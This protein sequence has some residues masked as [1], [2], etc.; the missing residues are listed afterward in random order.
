M[1]MCMDVHLMAEYSTRH[2]ILVRFQHDYYCGSS[3]QR[4]HVDTSCL[5]L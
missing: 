1:P 5:A 3:C 4:S 2:Q